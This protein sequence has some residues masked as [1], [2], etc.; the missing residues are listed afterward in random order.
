MDGW[1]EMDG[2]V[3]EEMD[4]QAGVKLPGGGNGW[5]DERWTDGRMN[6]WVDRQVSS[7]GGGNGWMDGDG[8]MDG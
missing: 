3:D 8:S 4:G 1:M 2:W 6:R 5:M 7:P